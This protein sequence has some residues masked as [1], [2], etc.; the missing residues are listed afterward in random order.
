MKSA[1]TGVDFQRRMDEKATEN[2][3]VLD[4]HQRHVIAR[5]DNLMKSGL[6]VKKSLLK[7]S[8]PLGGGV[9][10]WGKVGRG[11]SFIVDSFFSAAPIKKKRRVHFHD[12]L[13]DLH[14]GMNN[15]QSAD[16]SID[17][18]LGAQLG[19]CQLV[20]FDE[21]H[22]HDIGDAMLMKSLL[23][24]IVKRGIVLVATSNY[25][26][27]QLLSNPLY[28]ARFEPSIKLIRQYL[29]VVALD[30]SLDYRS[31]GTNHL[32]PFCEGAYLFPG[33]PA[34]RLEYQ[35]PAALPTKISIAVGNRRLSLLSPAE[36]F[37]HFSFEDL[38]EGPTAVIDYL[39]LCAEYRRW[40]I[41]D[42]PAM[43]EVSPATQQRFINVIDVLYDQ[44]CQLFIIS[45]FTLDQMTQ[46]AE[47]E[48][49]Q[50]TRSRLQQLIFHVLQ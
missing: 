34:Q 12:F 30:G 19:D 4:E 27:E 43:A 9:Y 10:I 25:P 37:L 44:Q 5:L 16:N 17:A 46:G 23:E 18:V 50:R 47:Q 26:P 24:L 20:C 41:Q 1:D 28:H 31:L 48:D 33:T 22:L 39:T 32:T 14:R 21:L 7:K 40:I 35:L 29:E 6:T 45:P 36:N 38:C 15:P 13:R 8:K 3:F 42:V 2:Q 11:K 49:I